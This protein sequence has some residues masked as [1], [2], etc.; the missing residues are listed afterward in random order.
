M[1]PRKQAPSDDPQK[2]TGPDAAG[3]YYLRAPE[4]AWRDF[5]SIAK[6]SDASRLTELQKS[7]HQKARFLPI[8]SRIFESEKL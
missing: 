6:A 8:T 4:T 1:Q 3:V 5:S 2:S 7:H